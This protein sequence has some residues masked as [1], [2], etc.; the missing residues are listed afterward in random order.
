MDMSANSFTGL[1]IIGA[2]NLRLK[3]KEGINTAEVELI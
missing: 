1:G 3:K 2:Q